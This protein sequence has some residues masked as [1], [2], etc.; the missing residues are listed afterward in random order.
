MMMQDSVQQRTK[1]MLA[2]ETE[3]KLTAATVLK[4]LNVI[5]S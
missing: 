1:E 4:V 5:H 2:V 3:T